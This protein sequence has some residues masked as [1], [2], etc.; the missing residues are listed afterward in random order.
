MGQYTESNGLTLF[1]Q[2]FSTSGQYY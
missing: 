2:L 1:A